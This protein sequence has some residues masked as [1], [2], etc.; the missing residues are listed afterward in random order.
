VSA[1]VVG[2]WVGAGVAA[3]GAGNGLSAALLASFADPATVLGAL[4]LY[5][6]AF[7]FYGLAT[8]AIGARAR[9]NADAQNLARPLFAVLLAV[10]FAALAEAGGAHGLDSLV[11]LPPFTP[12]MLLMRPAEAAQQSLAI[13]LLALSTIAAGV[14]AARATSLDAPRRRRPLRPAHG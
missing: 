14:L 7:A 6:L 8:V 11:Y 2:A 13:G 12:F 5:G 1:V 3:A 4:G 9:D 10:F